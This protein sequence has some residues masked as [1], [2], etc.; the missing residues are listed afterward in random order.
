[1]ILVDGK[2]VYDRLEEIADPTHTALVVIDMQRDFLEA[3]GAFGRLGVDMSMYPPLRR[4]LSDLLRVARASGVLIVHVA[5]STL[6]DRRSDSPAH[7]R[8]NLRM[9]AAHRNDGPPLTYAVAGTWG[10]GFVEELAPWPGEM[11][12]AKHRSSAFWGTDLAMLLR[13]NSIQTVVAAGCTTEGCVESTARDALFED[14]YTV[15]AEDGVASDDP[16][17]HSASLLLM[18]HRFDMASCAALTEVW[19]RTLPQEVGTH[20]RPAS[21]G[22][23]Q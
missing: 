1:M 4:R 2:V 14:F 23:R 11:V 22:L 18:R 21:S 17:Q 15:V 7:I 3:E 20:T 10:Q 16:E 5:M 9:H 8:F 6:P 12:V 13:S 19:S